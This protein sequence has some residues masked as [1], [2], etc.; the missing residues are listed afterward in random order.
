MVGLYHKKINIV[1]KNKKRAFS[2]K[3]S[4]FLYKILLFK[5][6]K[7]PHHQNQRQHQDMNHHQD[8]H[9]H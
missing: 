5:I 3:E 4:P 1:K 6:S 9:Y 7:K 2:K 8:Y